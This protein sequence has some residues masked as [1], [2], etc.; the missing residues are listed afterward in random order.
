M[1]IALIQPGGRMVYS[2]SPEPPLGLAYLAASLLEFKNDLEIEI[3]DGLILEYETY[4][5]KI[6]EIKADIVGVTSTTCHLKEALRIPGLVK[7]KRAEFIIGGPGVMN[8]PSSKFYN[9]GYSIICYGEGEKTIVDIVKAFENELSLR[10]VDGISFLLDNKEIKTQPRKLI[11]SLDDIPF[12]AR[13]LLDMEKYLSIWKE[14]MGIALTQMISSR[15]CQFSCRFCDRSV[16]GRKIRFASP[17]KIIEEMKELYDKYNAETIFFEEDTFTFSKERVLRLCE[18]F[19]K[20]LPGKTWGANARIGTVD[21]EMLSKMKRAGCTNLLIGVESGSQR[22]LDFLGKGITVEQIRKTFDW[23]NEIGINGGIFLILG[24]PGEKQEDI[25]MTK[26]LIAEIK[27][28][29]INISFLTPLP[30][31]EIFEMTKHLIKDNIDFSDFDE[32]FGGTYKKEAFEIEPNESYRQIMGFFLDMFG[33]KIDPRLSI[34]DGTA[35]NLMFDER[36]PS[37]NAD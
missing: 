16:Y 11:E 35:H 27:P 8:T 36:K 9:H 12:P 6:L 28:F 37:S 26:E 5:K 10:D 21:Y 32:F 20:E 17:K 31:T 19:E 24:V 34:Y 33:D 15:G 3:I 1:K 29:L 2:V 14:K 13:N 4:I 30:G 25:D 22:I 18:S 23:I 7:E